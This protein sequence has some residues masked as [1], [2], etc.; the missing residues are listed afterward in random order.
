MD[1]F[2]VPD[3]PDEMRAF[4]ADVAPRVREQVEAQRSRRPD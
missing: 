4:M 3:E 2:V 1:T